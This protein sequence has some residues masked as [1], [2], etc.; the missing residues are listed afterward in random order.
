MGWSG[1]VASDADVVSTNVLILGA[2]GSLI[3]SP[4]GQHSKPAIDLLKEYQRWPNLGGHELGGP[5]ASSWAC[6]LATWKAQRWNEA[7]TVPDPN[8][9]DML[10]FQIVVVVII[11]YHN[12]VIGESNHNNLAVRGNQPALDGYRII[13]SEP[14]SFAKV[15]YGFSDCPE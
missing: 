3:Y 8:G 1:Y 5:K 10:Q 14:R 13:Y 15:I 11:G 2:S 12:A 7:V 9:N 6:W 4:N